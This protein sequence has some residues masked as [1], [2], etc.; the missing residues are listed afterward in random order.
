MFTS[1][2]SIN[3][4]HDFKHLDVATKKK[5]YREANKLGRV[6]KVRLMNEW[7]MKPKVRE[8]IPPSI[9]SN[10][11]DIAT[12]YD[13]IQKFFVSLRKSHRLLTEKEFES[14]PSNQW[15][16]KPGHFGRILGRDHFSQKIEEAKTKY[17]KVPQKVVVAKETDSIEVEGVE[18]NFGQY[19]VSSGQVKVYAEKIE[20]VKRMLTREEIDELFLLVELGNIVDI[21]PKNFIL[22]EDGLYLI[23][24]NIDTFGGYVLWEYMRRL[25]ELVDEKDKKYFLEKIALKISDSKQFK[26]IHGY[27]NL[28]NRLQNLNRLSENT[29]VL[30]KAKIEDVIDKISAL[31]SVASDEVGIATRPNIFHFDL[32][33]IWDS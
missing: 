18:Y 22:A 16:E 8:V 23:D 7:G 30:K 2:D 5:L 25:D 33:E 26:D 17:I 20:P 24:T 32:K 15:I 14:L 31:K 3:T 29:K 4:L 11:M 10:F 27:K 28:F 6:D 21:W 9:V 12:K 19:Q 1:L 13:I